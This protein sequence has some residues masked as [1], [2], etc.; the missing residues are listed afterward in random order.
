MLSPE[1]LQD[2]DVDQQE[3]DGNF[4]LFI[5][6][7]TAIVN[8]SHFA[9]L[10]QYALSDLHHDDLI[11][12]D[13]SNVTSLTNAEFTQLPFLEELTLNKVEVPDLTNFLL[14]CKH[15]AIRN[16]TLSLISVNALSRNTS[17]MNLRL[18]NTNVQASNS[19]SSNSPVL[20]QD[21]N[22]L[23]TAIDQQYKFTGQIVQLF[24]QGIPDQDHN[25][26]WWGQFNM[27][28][29]V[30]LKLSN[31][32]EMTLPPAED[33]PLLRKIEIG[34]GVVV[35]SIPA[36]IQIHEII[37]EDI[38]DALFLDQESFERWV[39]YL[40]EEAAIA[41]SRSKRHLSVTKVI[42]E[43]KSKD[44]STRKTLDL[45]G[46]QLQTSDLALIPLEVA[47]LNLDSNG[48]HEIDLKFLTNLE[49]LS[50]EASNCKSLELPQSIKILNVG[51]N[52]NL[53]SIPKLQL[54]TKLSCSEN[55]SL[56][57]I[58]FYPNL[59]SLNLSDM[60]HLNKESVEIDWQKLIYLNVRNNNLQTLY[61]LAKMSNLKKLIAS[62]NHLNVLPQMP[63]LQ[64]LDC[65]QNFLTSLPEL[66]KLS[67]L[68]CKSNYITQLN[69]N[70]PLLVNLIVDHN[71]LETL[72]DNV[73]ELIQLSVSHNKIRMLP[74]SYLAL[75]NKLVDF[76]INYNHISQ[77]LCQ[78]YK[79]LGE[80]DESTMLTQIKNTQNLEVNTNIIDK[81]CSNK[82]DFFTQ[83]EL[84]SS[85]TLVTIITNHKTSSIATCYTVH[86]L[87]ELWQP[88]Y[89]Q[90]K[91]NLK[92]SENPHSADNEQ[93]QMF[94]WNRGPILDKPVFKLPHSGDFINK[95]GY[96]MITTFSALVM[97]KI[98]QSQALGSSFGV[99]RVHGEKFPL[100]T[101]VPI[102][103]KEL[104]DL[105][106]GKS[107]GFT[108]NDED[109]LEVE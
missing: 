49:N 70:M 101:L 102:N 92:N 7:K 62:N 57:A 91:R 98:K 88:L 31:I 109:Y 30:R 80:I 39:E 83:E 73:P 103:R 95:N 6:N 3:D 81:I 60:K 61:D 32:Q 55:S 8:T 52:L 100:Y 35:K 99:S 2:F 86:S 51:S 69:N 40:P 45:S 59:T 64:E 26:V 87:I 75:E 18:I 106:N 85:D 27:N 17:L 23:E 63:N 108:P 72:P 74:Q 37:Y 107:I 5:A 22:I 42:E 44:P 10:S 41:R 16:M 21:F 36:Y 79:K 56:T 67:V 43:W 71:Q 97:V 48:L 34:Q 78:T 96:D 4:H 9:E 82:Q 94:E 47:D 68:I 13:L 24:L 28:S 1:F 93:Q 77:K 25:N 105:A 33:L 20:P 29:T 90:T 15:I 38:D 65:E 66:P 58:H 11:S 50:C 104:V 14:Y 46:T 19:E 76:D 84:A 89:E 53:T 54:L 12:I